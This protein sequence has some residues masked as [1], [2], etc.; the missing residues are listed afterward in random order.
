MYDVIMDMKQQM[1][2]L[3]KEW[4][5]AWVEMAFK[6]AADEYRDKYLRKE[7]EDAENNTCNGRAKSDNENGT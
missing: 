1:I 3:M 2:E 7:D 5:T 4:P 6:L